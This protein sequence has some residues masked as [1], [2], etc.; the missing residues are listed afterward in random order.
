MSQR[1][2]DAED[3]LYMIDGSR[4]M[5]ERL[6]REKRSKA[7]IVRQTLLEF[8][9]EKWP[10]S[11]YAWPLRIGITVYRLLGTP[12]KTFFDEI[13]PLE[14]EPISLELWRLDEFSGK[15]GAIIRDALER[16][17]F[18][19]RESQRGKRKLILIGDGGDTGGDPADAAREIGKMGVEVLSV[20]LGKE[21]S[22]SMRV[23]A[24]ESGGKYVLAKTADEVRQFIL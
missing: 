23:V 5:N 21:S 17:L 15:G 24:T 6:G 14:P 20:E 18:I 4:S 3:R 1:L 2:K 22:R 8:C 9:T 10:A 13:I 16:A 12:G 7:R 19:L 11:Y